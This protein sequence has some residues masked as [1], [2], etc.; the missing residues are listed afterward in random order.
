MTLIARRCSRLLRS[1]AGGPG[2]SGMGLPAGDVEPEELVLAGGEVDGGLFE[3]EPPGTGGLIL[4]L[5]LIGGPA[6]EF[7]VLKEAG[8]FLGSGLRRFG[9]TGPLC[10]ET[11][12]I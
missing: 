8:L 10:K 11:S 12:P 5:L 3:F 1:W 2:A 9:S 6:G 4:L 7:F